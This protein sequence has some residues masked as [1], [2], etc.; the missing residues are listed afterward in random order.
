MTLFVKWKS[1]ALGNFTWI[2]AVTRRGAAP[3]L[4][5]GSSWA[6]GFLG[7][8]E[9]QRI[10][11][12]TL[13][14]LLKFLSALVWE[15]S[16]GGNEAVIVLEGHNNPNYYYFIFS[17]VRP[18]GQAA[19][20]GLRRD[21]WVG[22]SQVGFGG[23]VMG[24]GSGLAGCGQLESLLPTYLRKAQALCCTAVF[25]PKLGLCSLSPS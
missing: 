5:L 10:W 6:V 2:E 8:L 19:V 21:V 3:T 15:S 20:L 1:G 24:C 23:A 9:E 16:Q 11:P 25:F 7:C 22:T 14:A 18:G 12:Q 4:Q 17:P 13:G